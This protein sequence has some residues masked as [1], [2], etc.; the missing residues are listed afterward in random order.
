[1]GKKLTSELEPSN[2][3]MP[4]PKGEITCPICQAAGKEVENLEAENLSLKLKLQELKVENQTFSL[5]V[6]SLEEKN[7]GIL[8]EN[9]RLRDWIGNI[10]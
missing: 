8:E 5:L 4:R 9:D 3:L 6:K 2:P 1:M 10:I 7:K